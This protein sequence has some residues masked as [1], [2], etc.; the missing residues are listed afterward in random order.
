M[1][2]NAPFDGASPGTLLQGAGTELVAVRSCAQGWGPMMGTH[3]GDPQW[4][5]TPSDEDRHS[6]AVSL[7]CDGQVS[8]WS[9]WLSPLPRAGSAAG[10][11]GCERGEVEPLG[12]GPQGLRAGTPGEPRVGSL[13]TAWR[14]VS[15]TRL[16]LAA[17]SFAASCWSPTGGWWWPRA[18]GAPMPGA[19]LPAVAQPPRCVRGAPPA[20]HRPVGCHCP[21]SMSHL[22]PV[23]VKKGL[24]PISDRAVSC[25]VL[26][27]CDLLQRR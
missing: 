11:D 20:R 9:F 13:N 25:G 15:P 10:T 8:V 4:G 2:S 27:A 3:D 5:P 19:F 22:E 1:L 23:N 12:R 7:P 17:G 26:L 21:R 14:W 24:H 18:A 6:V 16:F